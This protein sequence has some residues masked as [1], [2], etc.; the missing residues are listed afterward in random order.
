MGTIETS[1]YPIVKEPLIFLEKILKIS[2][3]SFF[4]RCMYVQSTLDISN[5]HGTNKFVRD[6]ES[7]TYR[8]FEISRVGCNV[9]MY[10]CV[11]MY[12]WHIINKIL[13]IDD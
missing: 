9:F 6:I 3:K 12:V 4:V 8:V 13:H 10:V 1:N 2:L 11:P 7:S 5:C